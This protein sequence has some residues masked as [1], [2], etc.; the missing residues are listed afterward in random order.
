[1]KSRWV[2]NL[3]ITNKLLLVI[4]PPILG[5]IVFGSAIVYN[6]HQL[7]TGLEQVQVLSELAAVNSDLVHE[8]QKERGMSAGFIGSNGQSFVNTLPIQ[9]TATD[10][11]LNHF[12]DFVRDNVLPSTFSS[13]LT[14]LNKE[15]SRLNSLRGS[16]NNLSVSVKDEVAYYSQLN[17]RLLAIVDQTAKEGNSQA[18]AIQAASFSAYLQMKERAGLERAVLSSTFGNRDFKPG[19]FIEFTSLVSEQQSYEERFLAL[20]TSDVQNK[21]RQLLNSRAIKDVEVLREIA[22]SGDSDALSAQSAEEWFSTSSAR[23]ERVREFEKS[24][25]DSLIKQTEQKSS[26]AKSLMYS[27]ILLM[28]V[29]GCLVLYISMTVAKYMHHRLHYLHD[30]VTAAQKN[31]DLSI[32]IKGDTTDELGK[33]GNA[34]N[35]MMIDFEQVIHRVRTNTDSLLNASEKMEACANV[36]QRDVAIGHSEAEQVA[37]AMTEMSCTV[38]EIAINAVKASEASAAANIEAKEGN[39]GVSRTG[40]SIHLLAEEIGGAS[41]AINELDKDIQG[42][43]SVLGVI[44]GIAEQ[45]N[46]LALNAAIEAARAGEMGRGFA[47]VADEVRSLAQ[48]AQTST[49]DIRDMTERLKKGAAVA[50]LAME[51]GKAQAELSVKEAEQAGHDLEKIVNEVGVID[52][53]NE[54]IAAATHEQS[55]VSEEVNRNALKISEIYQNTQEIADEL[56]ALNETLLSDANM[57]AQE[58]SKFKLS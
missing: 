36:M 40:A 22:F 20:A 49:E 41:K 11:Q 21:Y 55:A 28:S 29:M 4:I 5:S 3:T 7:S 8:L 18:I 32:R 35:Q 54:Q 6:Q 15:F 42:I 52:A 1:M 26:S 16:V 23:I 30:C 50:V 33:L 58:V 27:I 12:K 37:S 17:K 46:L 43:V 25:S 34:F 51:K 24:L 13:E 53:M 45:T 10:T 56:S 39:L 9:R 31:F 47:V 48:R 44:S 19:M 57:M 14:R 38:Q 2:G